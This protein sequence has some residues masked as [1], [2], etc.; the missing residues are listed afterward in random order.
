MNDKFSKWKGLDR[1]KIDWNPEVDDEKCIG[2]GLCI[3]SCGREVFSYDP[4]K[5]RAVVKYPTRCMVSC[6]TCMTLCPKE[7]ISFPEKEYVQKLIKDN[8][9]I[10]YAR[11]VLKERVAEG[12]YS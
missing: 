10:A 3:T 6:S 11:K 2:C 9:L 1:T 5:N 8:K 12:K 4:V 7:A